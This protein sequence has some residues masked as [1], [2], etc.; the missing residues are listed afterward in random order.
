MK[1][2]VPQ[3]RDGG[4][5]TDSMEPLLPLFSIVHPVTVFSASLVSTYTTVFRTALQPTVSFQ[6]LRAHERNVGTPLR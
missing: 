2:E 6:L 4:E 1:L 3:L 5:S